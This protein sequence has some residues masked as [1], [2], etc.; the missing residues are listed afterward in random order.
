MLP[1]GFQVVISK[2]II[3]ILGYFNIDEWM[4]KERFKVRL[5]SFTLLKQIRIEARFR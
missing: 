4:E 1:R 2:I 5:I 3:E